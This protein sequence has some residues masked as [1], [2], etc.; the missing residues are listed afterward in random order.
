M[1]SVSLSI[2]LALITF[3]AGMCK[4]IQIICRKL[5]ASHRISMTEFSEWTTINFIINHIKNELS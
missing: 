4:G 3:V 1:L 5:L 2:L